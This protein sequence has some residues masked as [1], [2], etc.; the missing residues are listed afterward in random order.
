MLVAWFEKDKY[1]SDK[2]H[3]EFTSKNKQKLPRCSENI[4]NV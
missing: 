3:I 2:Y 4:K 1:L